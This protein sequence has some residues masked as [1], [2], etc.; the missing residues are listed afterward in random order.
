MKNRAVCDSRIGEAEAEPARGP[1]RYTLSQNPK[2]NQ[3][4]VKVTDDAAYVDSILTETKGNVA[5]AL[6]YRNPAILSVL[7]Q[8]C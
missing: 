6:S 1:R 8:K 7:K 3:T 4:K 2:E 5:Q